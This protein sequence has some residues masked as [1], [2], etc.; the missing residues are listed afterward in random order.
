MV[1]GMLL[2][3]CQLEASSKYQCS[4]KVGVMCCGLLSV[5]LPFKNNLLANFLLSGNMINTSTHNDNK[6]QTQ[7]DFT[8]VVE[9]F[10]RPG[11]ACTK[12]ISCIWGPLRD[13]D[14]SQRFN[15]VITMVIFGISET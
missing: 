3:L 10:P 1:L 7:S 13:I 9:C 15:R 11:I 8:V 12:V 4:S 2:Q 5:L 14:L 6:S